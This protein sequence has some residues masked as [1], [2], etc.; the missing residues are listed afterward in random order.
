MR[1]A[2]K[3]LVI[4]VGLLLIVFGGMVIAG[5]VIGYNQEIKPRREG[6]NRCMT[7]ANA[8]EEYCACSYDYAVEHGKE[9]VDAGVDYCMTKL[10][11]A[12]WEEQL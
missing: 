3:I 4:A 5:G 2:F 8:P 10:Y 12:D 9:K 6:I 7:N 11:G 1:K